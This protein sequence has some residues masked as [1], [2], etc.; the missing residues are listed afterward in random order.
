MDYN[1]WEPIYKEILSDFGFDQKRDEEAALLLSELLD[2]DAIEILFNKIEGKD[3]IICGNGPSLND[4]I[5]ELGKE[6]LIAADGATSVLLK[7]GIIPDVI[8]TDLDG[9]IGDLIYANRLD[10]LMVVH[11]HGDNMGLLKKVVPQLKD[12]VGTTQ[13]KPF[14]IIHNFGGFT[15]GDRSVFLAKSMSA[16]SIRLIGFD[17]NDP[18][19][20]EIKKKK[21]KWAERLISSV[22]V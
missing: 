10:A 20:S 17:Y 6:V 18:N 7:E 9:V 22:G 4:D 5:K 3:V 1:E 21:L 8:V 12:V 14:G 16:S 13:S 19:A 15:D 2:G 11:A